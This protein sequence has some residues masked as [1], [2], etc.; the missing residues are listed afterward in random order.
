M[1]ED[2]AILRRVD[3]AVESTL[4][5]KLDASMTLLKNRAGSWS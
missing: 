5:F 2:S 3:F 4:D 1:F